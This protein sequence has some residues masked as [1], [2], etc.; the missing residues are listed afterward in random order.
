M[1][2]SFS[3]PVSATA[4]TIGA[5]YARFAVV[6]ADNPWV[7]RRHRPSS[8][9]SAIMR[10][11]VLLIFLHI[12][13]SYCSL[14]FQSDAGELALLNAKQVVELLLRSQYAMTK[15]LGILR[16]QLDSLEMLFV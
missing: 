3:H 7:M 14:M 13:M 16:K 9:S 8:M 1:G 4:E 5:I 2:A 6:V 11:Y 12:P 15:L 10:D